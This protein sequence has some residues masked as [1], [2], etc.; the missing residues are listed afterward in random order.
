M[1]FKKVELTP[2]VS[3]AVA[4]IYMASANGA[5]ENEEAVYLSTVMHGENDKIIKA[6]KYI[7]GA[8]KKGKTF[9][10]F[11]DESNEILTM[12]QKECIIINLIDMMLSDGK[13]DEYEEKLLEKVIMKYGFVSEKFDIYKELMIKKNDHGVFNIKR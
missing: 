9:D 5:I 4:L 11:L 10:D 1:F 3:F 2:K 8:I 6:N 13:I 12:E 7:K